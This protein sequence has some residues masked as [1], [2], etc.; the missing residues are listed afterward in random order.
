MK[1]GKHSWAIKLRAQS[2]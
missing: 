2:Y 1:L